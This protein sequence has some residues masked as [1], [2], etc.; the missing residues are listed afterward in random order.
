MEMDYRNGDI[1]ED[2]RSNWSVDFRVKGKYSGL[3]LKKVKREVYGKW[4]VEDLDDWRSSDC[5]NEGCGD[6][7]LV[8]YKKEIDRKL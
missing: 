8:D 2:D 6:N 4:R 7:K 3:D 1:K 5:W